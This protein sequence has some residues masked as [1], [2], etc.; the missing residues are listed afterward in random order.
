MSALLVV[1]TSA[2]VSASELTLILVEDS[3]DRIERW[4]QGL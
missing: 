4:Y 1:E 3:T 2:R